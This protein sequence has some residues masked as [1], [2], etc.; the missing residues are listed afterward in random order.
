MEK[1]I[2]TID[3]KQVEIITKLNDDIKDDKVLIDN[4]LNNKLLEDTMEI[5]G[6]KEDE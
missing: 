3:G 6:I 1:E 2:I 5:K 4:L